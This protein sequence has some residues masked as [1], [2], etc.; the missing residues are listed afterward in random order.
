MK[1]GQLPIV[2][3]ILFPGEKRWSNYSGNMSNFMGK[4]VLN[5]LLVTD[6]ESLIMDK[7]ALEICHCLLKDGLPKSLSYLLKDQS[8]YDLIDYHFRMSD[9]LLPY[10]R[11]RPQSLLRHP[12]GISEEGFY[13]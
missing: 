6:F 5:S 10:L 4:A 7:K 13:Q 12:N 1:S 3:K 8:K 2:L 9:T 11:D